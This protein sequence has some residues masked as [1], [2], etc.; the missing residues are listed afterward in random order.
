MTGTIINV[1]AIIIGSLIGVAL[2]KGI[3][4]RITDSIVKVQGVAIIVI[5]LNGIIS[6]M[7]R[8]DP[9][10]GT[11]SDSGGLLLLISMVVGCLIG[12][13]LR[14][15]DRIHTFAKN[16]ESRFGT[17]DFAKGFVSASII[18]PIGAMA[19][20]GPL[21]DGLLGDTSVLMIKSTL[22]FVIS[23]V[24]ASTLGIGV[25][26]S[27]IPVFI[28]QGS[29]ALLAEAIYPFVSPELLALF[30]MTGYAVVLCIGMNFTM[31]TKI[32]VANLLPALFIPVVYY[33]TWPALA[34][35][36]GAHIPF[37]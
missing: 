1:V 27:I 29:F 16:V 8:V 6:A 9:L 24:L 18:F 19:V 30:G 23:I 31:D 34:A 7:F 35:F 33:F 10:T 22:D 13:L 2:K 12:E 36:L 26:F 15:E 21:Y 14:I 32:K 25:L 17:S 28:I 4:T 37:I 5:S 20:I 3:P 11:I